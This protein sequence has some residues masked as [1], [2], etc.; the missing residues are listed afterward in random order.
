M[1]NVTSVRLTTTSARRRSLWSAWRPGGA[2]PTSRQWRGLR[3]TVRMTSHPKRAIRILLMPATSGGRRNPTMRSEQSSRSITARSSYGLS[4]TQRY[5][6][7]AVWQGITHSC[8]A[9]HLGTLLKG[10]YN[11]AQSRGY[12]TTQEG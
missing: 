3:A 10:H 6:A 2:M 4:T 7:V 9:E 8:R 12:R 1:D 11:D 5:C